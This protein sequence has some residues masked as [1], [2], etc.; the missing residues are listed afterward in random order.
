MKE[1][2]K[3]ALECAKW[4]LVA[5]IIGVPWAMGLLEILKMLKCK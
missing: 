5:N 4:V 2:I 1:F 3:D